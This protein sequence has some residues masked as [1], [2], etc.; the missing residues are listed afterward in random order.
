MSSV[1]LVPSPY[2]VP[3]LLSAVVSV[4]L[5]LYVVRHP[6]TDLTDRPAATLVVLFVLAAEWSVA[7]L[8]RLV[9]VGQQ[10]KLTWVVVEYAGSGFMPVGWFLLAAEY[11]GHGSRLTPRRIALLAVEPLVTFVLVAT[12][13]SHQLMWSD[14]RLADV[15]SITVLER[16]FGPWFYVHIAYSYTLVVLGSYLFVRAFLTSERPYRGQIAALIAAV[17]APFVGNVGFVFDLG[18]LSRI[19]FTSAGFA[20][21]NVF[22]L[23]AIFRYRLLDLTPISHA[24]T[25][26]NVRDAYV[27]VDRDRR[28]V[29]TNPAAR[30]LF[31][32]DSASIGDPVDRSLPVSAALFVDD[33][34]L[35]PVRHEVVMNDA[36]GERYLDAL[37]TPIVNSRLLGWSLIF[38]DITEHKRR[39]QELQRQNE[40]L[41]EFASVVAHDL[42]NPMNVAQGRVNLAREEVESEHLEIAAQSIARIGT[43]IDES[44]TLAREGKS[45]GALER[46][47]LRT[48]V[49][50]CWGT[51]ST[52]DAS[53]RLD[54]DL[55]IRADPSRLQHVVENLLRNAVEHGGD[56][57][58]VRVGSLA[59]GGFYV[60]DDGPG[61]PPEARETVFVPGYTRDRNG[62]G[63]GLTIVKRIAEAHGWGVTVTESSTGGA[64][65]EFSGVDVV[66]SPPETA[67]SAADSE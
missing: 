23:F 37:V 14:V 56:D 26:D 6:R 9:S 20:L 2:L 24:V 51:V 18:P 40:R 61:I 17:V 54:A 48:V 35:D 32:I 52:A 27:V 31:D 12:N 42:R 10:A 39:E 53:L 8:L 1:Q 59:D 15:G 60:E 43:I 38:R 65:F 11:A 28:L 22:L 33:P 19:E 44:L 58:V 5:A 50:Q 34:E 62:T 41:D 45:V 66:S 47:D 67:D 13:P 3:F 49:E 7:Y 36:D 25:V 55:S 29:H 16:T 63:L 57:V 30:E 46:V 4:L 21:A 64:R